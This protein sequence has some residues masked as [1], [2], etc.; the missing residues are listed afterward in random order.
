MSYITF[1]TQII[2]IHIFADLMNRNNKNRKVMKSKFLLT[3]F[4]AF[5]LSV[6]VIAKDVSQ[7]QAEKVAINLF[8]EKSNV[9]NKTVDFY[10]LSIMNITKVE[11]AYYV[12]NLQNGWVL[13]AADD[14][15][16]PVLGYNYDGNFIPTEQQDNNVKSYLKHFVDQINFLRKNNIEADNE[17]TDQWD[18]YLNS[19][20]G[21]L[22][23]YRGNRDQVEP[24]CK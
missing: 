19:E 5:A 7:L 24:I 17:V 18:H 22:L 10:D 13:I 6:S 16:I 9:F 14:A 4:V 3:L 21:S 15:M 20:P 2:F 12:V 1:I 8:F 11:D 23:A